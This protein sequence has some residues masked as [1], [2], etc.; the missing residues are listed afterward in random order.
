MSLQLRQHSVGSLWSLAFFFFIFAG[1]CWVHS[2][3]YTA[4]ISV[5]HWSV[6]LPPSQRADW[7]AKLWRRPTV[8]FLVSKHGYYSSTD[9]FAFLY[10]FLTSLVYTSKNHVG[11]CVWILENQRTSL[12]TWHFLS[13]SLLTAN[14]FVFPC[15]RMF[16][17]VHSSR[18]IIS[19]IANSWL[20]SFFLL[21]LKINVSKILWLSWFLLR[22]LLLFELLF[23]ST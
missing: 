19:L 2:R 18:V 5:L 1:L 14:P 6:F 8:F 4:R 3:V 7:W 17:S 13:K 12:E 9:F 22:I 10:K 11:I 21:D 23:L 20:I 16:L 15:L